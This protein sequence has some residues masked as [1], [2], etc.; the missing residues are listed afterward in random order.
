MILQAHWKNTFPKKGFGFLLPWFGKRPYFCRIFFL[1]PSLTQKAAAPA[2][3]YHRGGKGNDY[4]N[5][6]DTVPAKK[7]RGRKGH[8]YQNDYEDDYQNDD[9]YEDSFYDDTDDKSGRLVSFLMYNSNLQNWIFQIV[10]LIFM[11]LSV[12]PLTP[13]GELFFISNFQNYSMCLISTSY[14]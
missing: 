12:L 1:H 4:Q 5:F 8:D 3:N 7:H 6:K 14:S 13:L 11:V 9:S 10:P 2:K